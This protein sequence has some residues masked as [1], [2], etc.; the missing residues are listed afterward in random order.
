MFLFFVSNFK[1]KTKNI[2]FR[3][4]NQG[5]LTLL[6]RDFFPPVH[7][8]NKDLIYTDLFVSFATTTYFCIGQKKD[9]KS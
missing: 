5:T 3:T 2:V 7:I 9:S 4:E 1:S 8:Q 6:S